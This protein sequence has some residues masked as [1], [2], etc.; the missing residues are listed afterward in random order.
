M[1]EAYLRVQIRNEMPS[2]KKAPEK[3]LAIM[4]IQRRKF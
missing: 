2:R 1:P 4:A 3:M